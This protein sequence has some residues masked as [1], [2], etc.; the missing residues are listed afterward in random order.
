MIA[1]EQRDR[2]RIDQIKTGDIGAYWSLVQDS[3]DDLKW[4]GASPFYTFMKAMPGASGE[5]LHYHQWQIDPHSVVTF[6]AMR[7]KREPAN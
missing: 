7:F 4:C 6:G 3:Q 2:Q 1:I 5:L